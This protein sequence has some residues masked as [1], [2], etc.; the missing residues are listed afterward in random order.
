MHLAF[1][2][3]VRPPGGFEIGGQDDFF[4]ARHLLGLGNVDLQDPG[5]MGR[6][7]LDDGDVEGVRGH[8]QLLVV[9]VIGEA[10]DL[11]EGGRTNDGLSV[12]SV[13][14]RIGR[15]DLIHGRLAPDDFCRLHDRVDD[16][17]V[18]CAAADIFMFLEPCP[19][20]FARRVDVFQE[21]GVGG[22]DE[23]RRAEAALDGAQ[24]HEGGLQ[25]VKILRG[26]DPFQRNDLAVFRHFRYFPCAGANELPVENHRA[27]TANPRIAPHLD[28]G[29]PKAPQHV[30]QGVFRRVTDKNPVRAVDLQPHF[31][32]SH[33]S[34]LLQKKDVQLFS[35]IAA[36]VF[37]NTVAADLKR[38]SGRN[39]EEPA[40]T[41]PGP[42]PA[43]GELY[44]DAAVGYLH[45]FIG[46][47]G[48]G[49]AAGQH[50][51]HGLSLA[52]SCPEGSA[53]NFAF[54]VDVS[55]HRHVHP[56]EHIHG[57]QLLLRF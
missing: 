51:P 47:G 13:F 21:Q 55:F 17:L 14:R 9:A 16:L 26:S 1:R 12:I 36:D 19:H 31:P 57:N 33:S 53:G 23:S 5:M 15:S 28:A 49:V 22:H 44:L 32:K 24:F 35:G 4:D 50:D 20:F 29:E 2:H 41:V 7:G 11:C 18:S 6:P 42:F 30:R 52:F 56:F 46:R 48:E 54:L 40:F 39:Q 3:D 45:L 8:L 27:G 38:N 34:T 10:A 37:S 25:G 43:G